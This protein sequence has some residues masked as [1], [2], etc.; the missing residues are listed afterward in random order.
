M[1]LQH[2]AVHRSELVY[3]ELDRWL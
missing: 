3:E 1:A 2:D